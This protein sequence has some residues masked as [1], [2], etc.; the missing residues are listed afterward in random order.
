MIICSLY[1]PTEK[2]VIAFGIDAGDITTEDR[3]L[4]K[5]LAMAGD[6]QEDIDEGLL[7]PVYTHL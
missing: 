7:I 2:E 1:A 6:P 4:K 5:A 3:A